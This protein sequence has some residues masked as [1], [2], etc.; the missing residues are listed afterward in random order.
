MVLFSH[1]LPYNAK[2]DF[3]GEKNDEHQICVGDYQ[4]P[5]WS[6]DGCHYTFKVHNYSS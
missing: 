6:L 3:H 1:D 2:L 4:K 5:K